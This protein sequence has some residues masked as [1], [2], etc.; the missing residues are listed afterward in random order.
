[1]H[2]T[3]IS[4]ADF[5]QGDVCLPSEARGR[6]CVPTCLIFLISIARIQPCR[7]INT[8]LLNEILY[9]GS[10][11][12]CALNQ[13]RNL[14]SHL[15]SPTDLPEHITWRNISVY[16]RH[17][18]IF[19]GF[20]LKNYALEDDL[21]FYSLESAFLHASSVGKHFIIV[22]NGISVGV[23][24]DGSIF[25]VFDSHSRDKHGLICSSGKCVLGFIK[26]IPELSTH[27]RMLSG[28]GN[29]T[30]QFD[31]HVFALSARRRCVQYTVQILDDRMGWKIKAYANKKKA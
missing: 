6:Q 9:A 26:T 31:L 1:M 12:Y 17:K 5:H 4:S 21:N 8:P 25:Y 27:I 14:T 23:Y 7:Q 30:I 10:Y 18:K 29:S 22:F 28:C 16:I 19:S 13:G 11:L 24:L 2:F 20:L 15:T 3:L